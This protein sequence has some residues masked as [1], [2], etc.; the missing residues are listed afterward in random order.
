MIS[1]QYIPYIRNIRNKMCSEIHENT[2]V[3]IFCL[4]QGLSKKPS[5]TDNSKNA[6]ILG[7]NLIFPLLYVKKITNYFPADLSW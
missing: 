7:V 3:G 1:M 2:K 6:S 5:T 4:S